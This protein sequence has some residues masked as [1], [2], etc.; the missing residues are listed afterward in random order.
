MSTVI[1]NRTRYDG[2]IVETVDDEG[3][4]GGCGCGGCGSW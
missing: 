3:Y 4:K 2:E 1:P